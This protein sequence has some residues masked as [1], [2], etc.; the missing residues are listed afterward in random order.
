M[1]DLS[2]NQFNI[3][4]Q[5]LKWAIY[6]DGDQTDVR[7]ESLDSRTRRLGLR[8]QLIALTPAHETFPTQYSL[9]IDTWDGVKR[10]RMAEQGKLKEP[11][12]NNKFQE[13]VRKH[14][15]HPRCYSLH[16]PLDW[17]CYIVLLT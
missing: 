5:I 7:C 3:G 16:V 1:K 11:F 8:R 12:E 6:D 10:R 4:K 13:Y 2:N 17:L 14:S 15:Q 9:H